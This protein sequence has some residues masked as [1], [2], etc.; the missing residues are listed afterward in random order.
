[1]GDPKAAIALLSRA[2]QHD[3]DNFGYLNNLGNFYRAT[4]NLDQAIDCYQ[5]AATI[6]PNPQTHY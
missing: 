2:V 1:M 3:P 5:Q 6:I 4:G